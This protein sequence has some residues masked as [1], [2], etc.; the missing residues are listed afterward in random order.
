MGKYINMIDGIPMGASFD[1]KCSVLENNGATK[2]DRPVL[3]TI[4]QEGMVCVVNNGPFAAAGYAY[5]E[6]EMKEFS[7]PG[8]QRQQQWYLFPDASKWID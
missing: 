4:W 7:Y 5:S 8:D 3:A 1:S 2:I 6:R